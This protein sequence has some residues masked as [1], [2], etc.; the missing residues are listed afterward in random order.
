MQ[1]AIYVL[2]EGDSIDDY[3]SD[4]ERVI[5]SKHIDGE[6]YVNVEK[7][8]MYECDKC[9]AEFPSQNALNG[10]QSAH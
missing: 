3:I 8:E 1:N 4:D 10:H 2:G 9:G 6:T 5:E 7:I